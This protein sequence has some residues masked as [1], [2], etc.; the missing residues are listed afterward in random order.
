[1]Q[2][3]I[4]LMGL[5]RWNNNIFDHFSLPAQVDKDTLT[6]MMLAEFAELEILY[7][8]PETFDTILQVWSRSRLPAWTKM[9]DALDEKYD[10]L[11]NKDGTI[12]ETTTGSGNTSQKL[13]VSAFNSDALHDSQAS[14]GN[15]SGTS[16][17]TR[18]ETGNIGVTT[19][20]AMLTEEVELRSRYDI[21]HL[22]MAEFKRRFC[23]MVY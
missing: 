12:T 20:Q 21:Y 11:W 10:P 22:I 4:S 8:D 1:M 23:L 16:T 2:A 19:S 7:P 15:S 18:R 5:Y 3:W 14:S 13:Q 6:T 17:T 9:A